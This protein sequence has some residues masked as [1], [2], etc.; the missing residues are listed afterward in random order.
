MSIWLDTYRYVYSWIDK[1]RAP[2]T[3]FLRLHFAICSDCAIPDICFGVRVSVWTQWFKRWITVTN[4][5][6][7]VSW[8]LI[9]NNRIE[10]FVFHLLFF[11]SL[12]IM[13]NRDTTIPYRT[14]GHSVRSGY[15]RG[16]T[17]KQRKHPLMEYFNVLDKA[18]SR[19]ESA[20]LFGILTS[21]SQGL[22]N[23]SQSRGLLIEWV[24][25]KILF[26]FHV[27]EWGIKQDYFPW[28]LIGSCEGYWQVTIKISWCGV[29][30]RW[31]KDEK[32][33]FTL[34]SF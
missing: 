13:R 31:K 14:P 10:D 1:K 30:G 7:K 12:I 26:K 22:S 29:P 8:A 15:S 18:S 34:E 23:R 25:D 20:Y 21:H 16:N 6:S 19:E 3:L 24:M 17:V 4:Y 33:N 2:W 28:I 9:M 32:K 11:S 27:K 5:I